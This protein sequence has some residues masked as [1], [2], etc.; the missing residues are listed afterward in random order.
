[1]KTPLVVKKRP[2][3]KTRIALLAA[4]GLGMLSIWGIFEW[5]RRDGGYSLVEA[6]QAREALAEQILA[7]QSENEELRRALALMRAADGVDREAYRRVARE[8]DDLQ[9]QIAELN[10]ELA[11]YR[12]IMTPAEGQAGLQVQTV[13]IEPADGD[14]SYRLRLILVQAGRNDRQVAGNLSVSVAGVGADGARVLPL[15]QMGG[16]TESLQYDFRYF[17][18][19]EQEVMLPDSFRA[20]R[21]DVRI[22]P[23]GRGRGDA[24]V[25]FPWVVE[26]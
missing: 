18:V 13:Q 1:M 19:L 25:S 2:P 8:L 21:V 15:E 20:E 23:K 9:S 12:G 14:R 11:F 3:P 16:T 6:G 24:E 7:L 22:M 5:G 4:I 10:E 26:N 17:Q